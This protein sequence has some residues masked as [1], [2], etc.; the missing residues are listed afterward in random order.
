MDD[1]VIPLKTPVD[2]VEQVLLKVR[3][4]TDVVAVYVVV[5]TKS[6]FYS[7]VGGEVNRQST[8]FAGAMLSKRSTS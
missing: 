4:A 6:A 7:L 5:E 3:D 1:N 8:A 2:G